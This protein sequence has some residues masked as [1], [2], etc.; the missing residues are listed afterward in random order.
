MASGNKKITK[1]NEKKHAR[2]EERRSK[3]QDETAIN[4]V[5]NVYDPI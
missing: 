1:R 4:H 5:V 3:K 2:K